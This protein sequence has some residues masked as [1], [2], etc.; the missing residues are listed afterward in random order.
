MKIYLMRTKFFIAATAI[1]FLAS[2]TYTS[3]TGM[4]E[5]AKAKKMVTLNDLSD[6]QD[7]VCG[8]ELEEGHIGDTTLYNGKVYGFCATG[9]KD[10]FKA[11]PT[12]FLDK[13]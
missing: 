12:A 10:K 8:M 2:C 1:F 11:N 4:E 9:C 6:K 13:K 7:H 5:P 3:K